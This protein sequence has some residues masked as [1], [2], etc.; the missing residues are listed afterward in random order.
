MAAVQIEEAELLN[1]RGNTAA[2]AAMLANKDA[3]KLVLQAQKIVKPDAVIPEIDA[4]APVDEAVAAL[5][6]RLDEEKAEREKEKR[7]R[8][9]KERLDSFKNSWE[10]QKQIV[11]DRFPDINDQGIEAIDALA[12]ER[13]IPDFE[14]AAD[15]F[16]R[17]N[18]PASVG[19][20][21]SGTGSWGFFESPPD[22]LK[23]HMKVLMDTKGQSEATT[24][25]MINEA[26]AEYRGQR[27]AA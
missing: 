11:R 15:T 25:K 5:T 7:E 13:G 3:R 9:E 16:R 14:S 6:K 22:N 12:K 2:L 18:P 17:L 27:R 1:H 24:N 10:R 4:R 8:D 23:E 19:D 20:S 21:S 26:L